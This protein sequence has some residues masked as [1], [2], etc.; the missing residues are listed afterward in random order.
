MKLVTPYDEKKHE[1]ATAWSNT[2]FFSLALAFTLLPMTFFTE[3][4]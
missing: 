2:S 4:V 1:Q 3:D